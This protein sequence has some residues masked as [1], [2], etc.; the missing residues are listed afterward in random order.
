MLI[1]T[2]VKYKPKIQVVKPVP[3]ALVPYRYPTTSGTGIRDQKS[4]DEFLAKGYQVGDFIT[5]GSTTDIQHIFSI[6]VVVGVCRDYQ[7]VNRSGVY[8]EPYRLVQLQKG[9]TNTSW[10]RW[11]DAGIYRKLTEEEL[12]R[13]VSHDVDVQNTAKRYIQSYKET[14]GSKEQG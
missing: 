10:C 11:G 7:K 14:F 6:H 9:G 1:H 5:A 4:L 12:E 13:W 3:P 2:I 8:M